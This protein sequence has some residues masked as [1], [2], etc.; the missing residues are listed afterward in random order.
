MHSAVAPFSVLLGPVAVDTS[1][2]VVARIP[3]LFTV[4]VTFELKLNP[5]N[6]SLARVAVFGW[7]RRGDSPCD[8]RPL[9][10]S[11]GASL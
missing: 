1:R 9:T 8:P 4:N 5:S 10:S 6:L 11:Q 7:H 3:R 2:P